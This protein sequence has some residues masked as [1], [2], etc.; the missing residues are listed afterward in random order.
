MTARQTRPGEPT[1]RGTWLIGRRRRPSMSA[2]ARFEQRAV[3][4]RQRPA[5]VLAVVA[6]L[7]ALLAGTGWLLWGSSLLAADTV[8]VEGVAADAD[9][10]EVSQAAAVPLGTPLVSID[11]AAIAARVQAVPFV[12]AVSV[13]RAW[14]HSVVVRVDPRVALFAVRGPQGRLAL[15]DAD[16]VVFREVDALPKGIPLVNGSSDTPAQEGLRAV[17]AV[18]RL[19]PETQRA[20]VSDITV[21]SASLVTFKLGTVQ[22]VWGGQ[23]QE[24][25][26][27]KVLQVLLATKPAVI[28]VSAP[29]TPVTR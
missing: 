16:A 28:D 8:R 9:R 27:L 23:G 1:Q 18:L 13:D 5:R 25:K 15:V 7:V 11:L 12:R 26:K 24:E 14:P 2:R 29:D 10:A 4:V 20:T 17:I 22:V 21:T 6:A 3:A 19:L